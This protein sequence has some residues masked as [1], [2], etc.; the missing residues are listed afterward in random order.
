MNEQHFYPNIA[1][2]R[3]SR[4]KFYTLIIL[5][6]ACMGLVVGLMVSLE[7]YLFAIFFGVII[8]MALVLIP[9]AIKSHPIKAGVPL[10]TVNN[11]EIT[12]QGKT[13]R[14]QDIDFVSVTILLNPVSKLD[15]ENKA[16][17]KTMAQK[18]PEE[19]MLGNIDIRL[20]KGLAK[21]G[22]DIIYNTVED[23][24][25]AITALVGAGVKHYKIVFNLKKIN[26]VA[27][28]S[29]T[30]AEVKKATLSEVSQKD[31]LKQL[32]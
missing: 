25:G 18:L 31:R 1:Y 6:V 8:L 28:F 3:A 24:I 22:E 16:Y 26:E 19:M 23:A 15:S 10:I 27:Q 30:K 5:L 11:K 4:K 21:R 2:N 13:Y 14:S 9:S 20:K 29:I 32:I 12:T 17:A 7:Q